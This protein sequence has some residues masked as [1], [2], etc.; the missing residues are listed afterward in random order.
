MSET[1]AWAKAVYGGAL[2]GYG[3]LLRHFLGWN[4]WTAFAVALAGAALTGI[5][6]EAA[7][8]T[9]PLDV[10]WDLID[11][12]EELQGQ[13][14]R[15]ARIHPWWH[16]DSSPRPH[17]HMVNPKASKIARQRI[18]REDARIVRLPGS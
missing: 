9:W 5:A 6:I 17:V 15:T 13:G 10:P 11:R 2:V 1:S 7:R 8:D 16:C 14:W 18:I 3:W 12:V 4:W